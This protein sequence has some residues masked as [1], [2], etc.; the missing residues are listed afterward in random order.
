MNKL[1]IYISAILSIFAVGCSTRKSDTTQSDKVI[2]VSIEP[3]RNIVEHL[4]DSSYSVVTML[5]SGSNPETFEPT[6]KERAKVDSAKVYF[7]TGVLPFEEQLQESARNTNFVNTSFGVSFIF[8]THGHNHGDEHHGIADPHYW[9]SVE[10]ARQIARNV[11][12]SLK[13]LYPADSTNLTIRLIEYESHLD[14]LK[15]AVK[16]RLSGHEDEAF[17]VWHPSLSYVA[18]EYD[19]HQ[20][21]V[22]AEGKDLSAKGLKEAIEKAKNANVKVFFFQ[23]EFDSR[24][25]VSINEGIG[26]RLIEVQPLDYDWEKQLINVADEIAGAQ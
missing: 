26:S 14:S 10:G 9:S 23:K 18:R 7:A 16:T 3:Q 24:Q 17:A 8:D 25:A 11:V 5:T 21:S 19:L 1:F 12:C 15:E 2:V 20:I 13:E 22:G 6:M 4:V